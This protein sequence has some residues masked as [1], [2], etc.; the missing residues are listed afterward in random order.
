MNPLALRAQN[1]RS[2]PSL[3]FAIPD[4]ICAIVGPNGA[5]KSTLLSAIELALFADGARDLALSTEV[6]M[7]SDGNGGKLPLDTGSLSLTAYGPRAMWDQQP[8]VPNMDDPGTYVTMTQAEF[9]E[10]SQRHG[11]KWTEAK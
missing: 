10:W 4:G 3:E 6:G 11:V 2:Y 1:L 9:D 7:V 8:Y 5:G